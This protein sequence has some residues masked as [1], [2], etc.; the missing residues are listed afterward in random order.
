MDNIIVYTD[1]GCHNN[2]P[3]KGIGAFA[4]V[5]P[6]TDDIVS[7]IGGRINGTTNNRTEMMAILTAIEDLY[8][9]MPLDIYTDSGYCVD[10]FYKYI[11]QWIA[12]GWHTVNK[13]SVKNQDLWSVFSM[14]RWHKQFSLHLMRGHNKDI[15]VERAYWNDICDN[16]CTHLMNEVEKCGIY[17]MDYQR[18]KRKFMTTQMIRDLPIYW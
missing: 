9:G 10:G 13:K 15:N 18:K 6:T 17:Q 2:P 12:N 5:I 8:C 16:A 11:D 3:R 7:V 14:I 1:G 4:Y